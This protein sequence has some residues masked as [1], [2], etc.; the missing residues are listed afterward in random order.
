MLDLLDLLPLVPVVLGISFGQSSSEQSQESG[1][2]SWL[3]G[4]LGVTGLG[5]LFGAQ[6]VRALEGQ[7]TLDVVPPGYSS[8]FPEQGVLPSLLDR[9]TNLGSALPTLTSSGLY[10]Q[11]QDAFSTAVQQALGQ[12]SGS[13]AQ[14]GFLRPENINAIAGSAAQNVMPQFMGLI[15]QNI[16]A[17][18]L[19]MQ[20]RMN[21]FMDFLK[22]VLGAPGG[23]GQGSASAWNVGLGTG[24]QGVGS[25]GITAAGTK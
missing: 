9:T 17:P 19:V 13:Y 18:E 12:V 21:Q 8:F 10:P 16:Q 25:G 22:T 15:G 4:R 11:Q 3:R 2:P 5:G 14:R 20:Q 23:T 24:G 1:L 7:N 6:P